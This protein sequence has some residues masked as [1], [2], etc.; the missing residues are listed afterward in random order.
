MNH[1]V[2]HFRREPGGSWT[3][4]TPTEFMGPNGRI[5]VTPGSR[6]APGTRFMGVDLAAWLDEQAGLRTGEG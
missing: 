3:C 5:Q 4:V 6:F 1:F 2:K